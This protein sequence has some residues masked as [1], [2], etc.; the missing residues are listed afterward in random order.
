MKKISQNFAEYT[1]FFEENENGT[2]TVTVPSLPGL[3]TEVRDM[4]EAQAVIED[5]IVC[6]RDGLKKIKADVPSENFF[7]SMRM[8]VAV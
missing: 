5:A 7:A 4:K 2:Y 3:V 8:R 6:Y 1:A